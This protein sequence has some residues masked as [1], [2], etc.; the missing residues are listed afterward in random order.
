MRGTLDPAWTLA[1]PALAPFVVA[2]P[3]AGYGWALWSYALP[4]VALRSL[5]GLAASWTALHVGTMWLNA[6]RDR[7][8][9]PV[10]LGA[11]VA[12]PPGLAWMGAAALAV[13]VLVAARW[14]VQALAPLVLCAALAVAYSTPWRPRAAWK[15]HPWAGPLT[16]LLGYGALSPWAGARLVGVP[17]DARTA[18]VWFGFGWG[19]MACYLLAQAFQGDEDRARGDRTPVARWGAAETLRGARACAAVAWGLALGLAAWGWLPRPVLLAVPAVVQADATLA[20]CAALP[21]G[22]GPSGAVRVARGWAAAVAW[23]WAGAWVAHG[24]GCA[25]G[26]PLAGLGTAGGIPSLAQILEVQSYV[27]SEL[28]R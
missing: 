28:V 23:A 14:A 13:A 17:L 16:N 6:A 19:V 7:D 18:W 22:G 1:R 21:D 4:A 5:L 25:T 15:G 11:P 20:R 26:A 2:L 24:Y 27:F 10:L 3:L 9:G 8:E 12:P